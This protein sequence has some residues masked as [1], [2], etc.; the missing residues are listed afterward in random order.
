MAHH[1]R[2]Q[3]GAVR[4]GRQRA[5]RPRSRAMT[6]GSTTAASEPTAATLEAMFAWFRRER[7]AGPIQHDAQQPIWQVFGYAVAE[8]ILSDP[9]RFSSDF[10]K[11]MPS[12]RDFDLFARGNFVR[13]DPPKHRK[14][15]GLVSKAFTPRVVT[16]LA[17][18]IAELTEELL[19]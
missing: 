12:Q 5:R 6:D 14:L 15:R 4:D 16:G 1:A 18:R 2:P 17:P 11:L 13:M 3:L 7:E 10:S 19:D 9:D 8:Q